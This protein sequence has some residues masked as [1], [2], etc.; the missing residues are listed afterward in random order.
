VNWLDLDSRWVTVSRQA[1][2]VVVSE[3][4]FVDPRLA[5]DANDP[6]ATRAWRIDQARRFAREMRR[7]GN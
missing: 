4:A 3:N 2:R 6:R 7:V 5:Y 1:G